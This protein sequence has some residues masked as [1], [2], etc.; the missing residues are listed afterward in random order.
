[1]YKKKYAE[2]WSTK[3]IERK[4]TVATCSRKRFR[5][6]NEVTALQVDFNVL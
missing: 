4:I 5:M 1:M 3:K 6:E 2:I